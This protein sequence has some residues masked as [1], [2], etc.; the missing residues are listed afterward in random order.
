MDRYSDISPSASGRRDVPFCRWD[1]V[2]PR[3]AAYDSSSEAA[4]SNIPSTTVFSVAKAGSRREIIRWG[5]L[6]HDF[7][8]R[9]TCDRLDRW[10]DCDRRTVVCRACTNVDA[11]GS[12]R[13]TLHPFAQTARV[14][15]RLA[16]ALCVGQRRPS[17]L[18]YQYDGHAYSKSASGPAR[19]PVCDRARRRRQIR[20]AR[21]ELR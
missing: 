16:H 12:H 14:P 15:L 8:F 4:S 19:K 11:L 18:S 1:S 7:V 3:R 21:P 2:R 6:D 5:E 20:L 9:K 13:H 17:Y 10:S